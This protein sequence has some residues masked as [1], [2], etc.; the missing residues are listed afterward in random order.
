M[1]RFKTPLS[2]TAGIA[3]AG[4]LALATLA[5]AAGGAAKKASA[6]L[7]SPDPK[8]SGSI[9]FTQE[10]DGVHVV[11]DVSGV[12]PGMHG[13][14]VHENGVCT[15]PDF[16]SAGGHFNPGHTPHACMPTDPRH[17][18]DFGNI[19]VGA[20][21]KGHLDFTLAGASL[22]GDASV[23]GKSIVLHAGQDDCSTQP[24][25]NSGD[26]LACGVIK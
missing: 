2:L 18:G 10:T 4:A 16:K 3:F 17:A 25:G 26:R 7:Q 8:V 22:S 21:G 11:A 1:T 19:T 6:K 14:H 20:D 23:I 13:I 24:S 15:P 5:L 12:P 9:H